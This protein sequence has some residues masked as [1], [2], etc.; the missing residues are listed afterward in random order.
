MGEGKCKSCA[1]A[2][3]SCT[4]LG[5]SYKRGPPKGYIH[6]IEQRWHQVESLLGA[7]LQ[8]PDPRVQ[9]V[10]SDLQQDDL[11]REILERVEMGP[12]GPSGR[13]TQSV[14][15]TKE[16]FFASVLKSN[17]MSHSRDPSRALRQSR[18][19][20][21]IVSSSQD[22]GL[23]VVPT[24]QWQDNLSQ[25][26]ATLSSN[27][28]PS[29]SSQASGY[30]TDGTYGRMSQRRRLNSPQPEPIPDWSNMYTMDSSTEDDE[31][32]HTT[33]ELGQLSLDEHKEVRFH[34]KQSGLHLLG[35]SLRADDRIEGGIWNLP[36]ARVWPATKFGIP[37]ELVDDVEVHLPPL[38]VQELLIDLYFTYTHPVFPIIHKSRF[39]SEFHARKQNSSCSSPANAPSPSHSTPRPEPTQEIT[40][41]LLLCMFSI[42]A[43]FLV[44]EEGHSANGSLWEA[45]SEYMEDARKILSRHTVR[46]S[47]PSI[48]QALILLG[49]REFGIG[50]ME[51]GWLLIGMGIRMAFDLGLNC[52]S[53]RWKIKTHDLFTPEE[54]QTRRQIWWACCLADRYGSFYMG[55]PV[56]IREGD[57]DTPL[58][59]IDPV[60]DR[61]PWC[62]L[63]SV[64]HVMY[65]P[66]PGRAMS[67]FC[68]VARLSVI[69]GTIMSKIYPINPPLKE[70]RQALLADLESRL[71]QW[72]HTLPE[73]LQLEP[74][75]RRGTPPPSILCLHI[76]YW[77]AVLI[78]HRAFIPNWTRMD[79]VV[80]KSTIGYRSFDLSR[81]AAC[82]ISSIVT[83][84]RE[85]FTMK[86]VSP[87][88]T[89]YLLSA[90]IMHVL[91]LTL[92]PENVEASVGLQQCKMALKE[93]ELEW[94]SAARAW[95]LLNGVYLGGNT[96][97]TI[98]YAQE[99][100]YQSRNKRPAEYVFERQ[101]QEKEPEYIQQPMASPLPQ[102]VRTSNHSN[103]NYNSGVQDLS[104]RMMAHM[105]GL[106]L[107]GIEP[108]TSYYPGYEWW[109]RTA[110]D[111]VST[112]TIPGPRSQST[113]PSYS[114][115]TPDPSLLASVSDPSLVAQTPLDWMPNVPMTQ[116][117]HQQM[118]DMNLN[119]AYDFHNFGV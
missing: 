97:N 74:N 73:H 26:I 95:E 92:R 87:L 42:A 103:L 106:D 5:P 90:G 9:G 62:P 22:H 34:G 94:P 43:R 24:K 21:E 67:S 3:T 46:N 107:P 23:S 115:Q 51:Q 4:F 83:T 2:D 15:S 13:R 37:S 12:Y 96:D 89:S 56:M 72:Y 45:G 54:T 88:M 14:E 33:N 11:A 55:R 61:E 7:L 31:F 111:T 49:Y 75:S 80:R 17:E 57:Y 30:S 48:V 84:Y 104:T 60:E 119:Y 93:M 100:N 19:S 50:S 53:S 99:S 116:E 86:R 108:S 117:S 109:P 41:L 10:I 52:D 110:Q 98:T 91:A 69:L 38:D 1:L 59:D 8:C 35:R 58:P 25:R 79:G 18:V 77:G 66:V 76:R 63:P 36:M 102:H 64:D 16:D 113:Q 81:S 27:T 20:R 44:D 40:P 105:L 68:A 70:S 82:H 6:A 28:V 71:D 78:L 47:R 39:L 32:R 114:G 118:P 65:N 85:T 101:S 112:N 29:S